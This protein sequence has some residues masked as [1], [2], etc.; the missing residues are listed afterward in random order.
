MKNE[1][2]LIGVKKDLT[3]EVIGHYTEPL[4]LFNDKEA[5]AKEY[6][7]FVVA[8][9]GAMPLLQPLTDEQLKEALEK[10]ID[11]EKVHKRYDCRRS[12]KTLMGW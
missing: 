6:K 5:Y 2:I 8:K 4:Y 12:D 10:G 7:S 11:N 3:E 1:W 9:V